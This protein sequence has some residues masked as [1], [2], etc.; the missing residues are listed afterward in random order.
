M[1]TRAKPA[2][3]ARSVRPSL[4]E[5]SHSV[6]RPKEINKN[7]TKIKIIFLITVRFKCI[8]SNAY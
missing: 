2:S 5:K 6:S 7:G 3:V 1:T 8:V 4:D